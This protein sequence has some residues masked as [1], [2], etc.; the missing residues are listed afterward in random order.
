MK[1]LYCLLAILLVCAQKAGATA[2]VPEIN[3]DHA[4]AGLVLLGGAVAM[5][6]GSR[7]K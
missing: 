7:S 4:V 3:P 1:T 6:F 2:G 5:Y